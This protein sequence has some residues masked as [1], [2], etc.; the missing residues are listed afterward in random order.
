MIN[1]TIDTNTR[2]AIYFALAVFSIF[3]SFLA[4]P[5]FEIAHAKWLAPT[6]FGLFALCVYLYDN[7]GWKNQVLAK[8]FGLPNLAGTYRGT[9]E[10]GAPGSDQYERYEVKVSISQTW[11][12][13]DMVLDSG[14]TLSH[15]RTCGFFVANGRTPSLQYT[16][17]VNDMKGHNDPSKYG[18]GTGKLYVTEEDGKLVLNGA[19]YSSKERSGAV[20]FTRIDG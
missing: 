18:E 11:S 5:V 20:H 12:K 6:T 2:P 16:Y 15:L 1:Y 3:A 19:Y 8:W 4:S 9:V 17:L 13:I 10:R 7:Y 14:D